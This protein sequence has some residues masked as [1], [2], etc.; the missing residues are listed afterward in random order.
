MVVWLTSSLVPPQRLLVPLRVWL[1]TEHCVMKGR[2]LWKLRTVFL[3]ERLFVL[4]HMSV[5]S[6]HIRMLLFVLQHMACLWHPYIQSLPTLW[7]VWKNYLKLR[8]L[9]FTHT[10]QPWHLLSYS[11]HRSPNGLHPLPLSMQYK[12]QVVYSRSLTRNCT[13]TQSPTSCQHSPANVGWL[14]AGV[15]ITIAVSWQCLLS[16]RLHNYSG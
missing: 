2:Y 11:C 4:Q 5:P 1:V 8:S 13:H 15:D 10:Q 3:A 16:I 12:V 9:T 6:L 14:S 7:Y